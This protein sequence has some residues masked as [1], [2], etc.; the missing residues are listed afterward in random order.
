[1][2]PSDP[3]IPIPP[4]SVLSPAQWVNELRSHG[5]DGNGKLC[6]L[7]LLMG[8]YA[9]RERWRREA[10]QD[11]SQHLW[12]LQLRSLVLAN[13]TNFLVRLDCLAEVPDNKAEEHA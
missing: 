9:S 3:P 6:Y 8:M 1:M 12:L 13:C 11:L 4:N 7:G 10:A 2:L 5:P